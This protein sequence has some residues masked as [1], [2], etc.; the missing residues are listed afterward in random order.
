MTQ[1]PLAVALD[2]A[3]AFDRASAR[4][5]DVNGWHEVK[6]N[7][8]SKVGVFDYHG[9]SLPGAPDQT[10][11]YRIYRPADELSDPAFL[12]SLRL[13]PWIDEH[14]MLGAKDIPGAVAA[15]ERGVHGVMGEEVRF[16]GNYVRTNLKVFSEGMAQLI[17]PQN[18][19]GKRDL[20]LGYRCTYD[21]TPGV[22]QGKPYDAVQRQL[23]GN[24]LALVR[25][26]RMGPDVA[27][28]DHGTDRL[29]ITADSLEH[30]MPDIDPNAEKKEPT[31]AEVMAAVAAL[32]EKVDAMI[33][34]AAADEDPEKMAADKAAADETAAAEKAAAE[35]ATEDSEEKKDMPAAMDAL[36][37]PLRTTI[38]EQAKT[39][40]ALQDGQANAAKS[41]AMDASAKISL[42]DRL[43][44]LVGV[45]DHSAMTAADVVAYGV[46]KLGLKP[47]AG[48]EAIALD[49]YLAGRAAAGT[50]ATTI[51][52][53][54]KP[55]PGG[56][57]DKY[58][59]PAPKE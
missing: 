21:W 2:R 39:I 33:S 42:V 11:V 35:K 16:D 40:K 52:T 46:D 9:S 3:V 12:D 34:A 59:N 29:T 49:S 26:G 44:P 28:L 50:T 41:V 6:D 55:K 27:V 18:P 17:D 45:F 19:K 20:S 48:T 8:I 57:V 54:S 22:F 47:A 23:R 24:H 4:I 53:D 58:L 56:V 7:P 37:K 30:V 14:V 43:K 36:L 31:L 10:K 38:A 51:A 32:A 25:E 15:E 5:A 1:S 13:L